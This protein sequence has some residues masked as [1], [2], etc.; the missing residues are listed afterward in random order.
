MYG[1][2]TSALMGSFIINYAIISS[3]FGDGYTEPQKHAFTAIVGFALVLIAFI[4]MIFFIGSI[5]NRK[6]QSIL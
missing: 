3:V 5:A 1:S 2:I 4:F 6:L